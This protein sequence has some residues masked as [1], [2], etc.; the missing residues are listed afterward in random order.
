MTSVERITSYTR[1]EQEPIDVQ[2]QPPLP[3]NWP[4]ETSITFENVNLQYSEGS[5]YA[6]RDL[7]FHIKNKEKVGMFNNTNVLFFSKYTTFMIWKMNSFFNFQIYHN[8]TNIQNKQAFI[9]RLFNIF[10]TYLEK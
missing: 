10:Q 4:S 3:P 9:Y 1:L 8:L 2:T 7:S 5:T 6:L